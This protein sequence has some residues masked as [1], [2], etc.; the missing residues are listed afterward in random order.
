MS[1]ASVYITVPTKEEALRIV[2][3]LLEQRL[4]AC[5]NI[6]EGATSLYWWEGKIETATECVVVAKTQTSLAHRV[7]AV[8]SELH[9]YDV[10]CITI[11]PI[12]RANRPY[13]EWVEA[14]TAP[15]VE[16]SLII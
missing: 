15:A 10:P 8:A 11:T 5:A 6:L 7:T 13:T 16:Q 14:E 1:L 12:L 9:S 2:Q 4:I 3:G